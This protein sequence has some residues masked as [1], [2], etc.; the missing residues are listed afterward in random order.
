MLTYVENSVGNETILSVHLQKRK[1][2]RYPCY[3]TTL[4]Y[5]EK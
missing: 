5:F 3:G 1:D 4:T 2:I